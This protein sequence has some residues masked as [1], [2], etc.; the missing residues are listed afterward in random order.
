M[1]SALIISSTERNVVFFAEILNSASI[2]QIAAIHTCGEA[3]RILLERDFDLVIVNAPLP[4]ETG[5]SLARHIALKGASQVILVVK[6]EFFDAVSSIC[7]GDGVLTISKP[8]NKSLFWSA[9]AL[10]K[11][12]QSRIKYMPKTRN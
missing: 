1:E 11:S 3:R 2:K 12:T 6:N 10:A 4:D 8:I 7:E 9:L 5:E